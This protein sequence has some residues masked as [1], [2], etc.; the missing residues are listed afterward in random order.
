MNSKLK[1]KCTKGSRKNR[2]QNLY[3]NKSNQPKI[4]RKVLLGI[5][6]II[7]KKTWLDKTSM[8]SKIKMTQA[9]WIVPIKT[10]RN[11]QKTQ[12]EESLTQNRIKVSSNSNF[13]LHITIALD[14]TWYELNWT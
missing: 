14:T 6:D 7:G 4:A 1:R 12:K 11:T 5:D 2:N 3:S 10:A 13:F 8:D 9:Q